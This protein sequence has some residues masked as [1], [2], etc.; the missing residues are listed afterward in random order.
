MKD[1]FGNHTTPKKLAESI[2]MDAINAKM[3]FIG[4]DDSVMHLTFKQRGSVYE[5]AR[6][7]AG[8]VSSTL[9][10]DRD[11]FNWS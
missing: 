8:R 10:Y 11:S 4:E 9:N 3:E 1:C 7:C 6:K 5:Q 2:L